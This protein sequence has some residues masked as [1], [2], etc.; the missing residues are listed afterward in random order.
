VENPRDR[1]LHTQ[2]LINY[3]LKSAVGIKL[4]VPAQSSNHGDRRRERREKKKTESGDGQ[5]QVKALT[6][7]RG[8]KF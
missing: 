8:P 4:S 6:T 2:K 7:S 3:A 1:N 5:E